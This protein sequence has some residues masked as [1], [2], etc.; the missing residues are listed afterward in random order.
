MKRSRC[1]VQLRIYEGWGFTVPLSD[2]TGERSIST[3]QPYGVW[4]IISP[5]TSARSRS[6]NGFKRHSSPKHRGVKPRAKRH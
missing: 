1:S 6:G 2:V 3:M 5:L 4:A